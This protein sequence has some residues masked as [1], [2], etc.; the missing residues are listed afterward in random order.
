MKQDPAGGE[1]LEIPLVFEIAVAWECASCSDAF[2]AFFAQHASQRVL[3]RSSAENFARGP[4]ERG[5]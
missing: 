2:G 5:E 3:S 1:L 4:V